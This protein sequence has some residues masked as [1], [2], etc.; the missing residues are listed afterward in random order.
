VITEAE[1][2]EAIAQQMAVDE[3]DRKWQAW[4]ATLRPEGAEFVRA[5]DVY[6]V[7]L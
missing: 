7:T 1:D 2:L 6:E 5:E 3:I 4:M